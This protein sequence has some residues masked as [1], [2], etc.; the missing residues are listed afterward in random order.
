LS[1]GLRKLMVGKLSWL[2]GLRVVLDLR[3]LR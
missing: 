3:L 2:R 1:G